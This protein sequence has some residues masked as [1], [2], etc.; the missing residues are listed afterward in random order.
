MLNDGSLAVVLNTSATE[1]ME[2]VLPAP[3]TL[4]LYSGNVMLAGSGPLH[5]GPRSAALLEARR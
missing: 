4:A 2:L 3:M 1:S 5:L